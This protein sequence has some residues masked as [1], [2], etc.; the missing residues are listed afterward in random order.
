MG[1]GEVD[2]TIWRANDRREEQKP[3]GKEE[4]ANG[5]KRMKKG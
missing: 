1:S 5:K 3:P 2:I 4:K